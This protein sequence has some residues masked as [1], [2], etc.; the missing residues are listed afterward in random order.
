MDIHQLF[1][2]RARHR[3]H[4]DLQVEAPAAV[5]VAAVQEWE[6]A[7]MLPLGSGAESVVT[8]FRNSITAFLSPDGELSAI[9]SAEPDAMVSAQTATAG[10]S[11]GTTPEVLVAPDRTPTTYTVGVAEESLVT[12][13]LR[14]PWSLMQALVT[15][16]LSANPQSLGEGE[17][18]AA[19]ASPWS[20]HGLTAWAAV[21]ADA[22]PV[23]SR[24]RQQV[25][26]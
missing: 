1:R 15:D 25:L 11:E 6:V 7:R 22:D 9:C 14:Q 4:E 3:L 18:S 26:S 8:H 19:R 16:Y 5:A 24:S 10:S 2:G 13:S 12:A 20:E 23:S 17:W 21:S